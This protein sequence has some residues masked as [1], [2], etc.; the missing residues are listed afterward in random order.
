MIGLLVISR[1]FSE[2]DCLWFFQVMGCDLDS[3]EVAR[4]ISE[5]KESF[6]TW[7]KLADQVRVLF[8]LT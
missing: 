6:S 7:L 2:R 1:P 3:E 5:A 8:L 4:L